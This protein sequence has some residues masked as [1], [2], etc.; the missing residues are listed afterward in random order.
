M[1]KLL[2][3]IIN[4]IGI[5]LLGVVLILNLFY[6]S[7]LSSEEIIRVKVNS[8]VYLIGTVVIALTVYN[9]CKIVKYKCT[10]IKGKYIILGIII[11]IYVLLQIVWINYRNAC[12]AVDQKTTYQVA[13]RNSRRKFK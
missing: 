3:S 8:F 9:I 11:I 10:K 7:E 5:V 12:P 4:I 1:N 2:K 13:V 6:T